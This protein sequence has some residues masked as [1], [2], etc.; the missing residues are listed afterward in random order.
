[1]NKRHELKAR[2]SGGTAKTCTPNQTKNITS[3]LRSHFKPVPLRQNKLL[4]ILAAI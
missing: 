1:M 3:H 4:A 2:A